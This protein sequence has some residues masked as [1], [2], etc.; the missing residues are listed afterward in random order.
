MA[1]E[2]VAGRAAL[3]DPDHE[4]PGLL[5]VER[6]PEARRE[7]LTERCDRARGIGPRPWPAQGP[8]DRVQNKGTDWDSCVGLSMRTDSFLMSEMSPGLQNERTAAGRAEQVC[9]R[10]A[11]TRLAMFR[12]DCRIHDTGPAGTW[13]QDWTGVAV[14]WDCRGHKNVI[15]PQEASKCSSELQSKHLDRNW[16]GAWWPDQATPLE[17]TRVSDTSLQSWRD[18]SE[19]CYICIV[20]NQQTRTSTSNDPHRIQCQSSCHSGHNGRECCSV[21]SKTA[22][23]RWLDTI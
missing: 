22:M 3:Q 10:S 13:I 12:D 6:G 23:Q 9:D 2:P 17:T 20:L 4:G 16:T 21:S 8:D 1:R 5:Q 11:K 7:G 19:N 14:P 15:I 18:V